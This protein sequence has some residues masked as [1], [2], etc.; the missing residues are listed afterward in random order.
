MS[1]SGRGGRRA[2]AGRPCHS[3]HYGEATRVIRVP[4]SLLPSIRA[5]LAA[6]KRRRQG[7]EEA[8]DIAELLAPTAAVRSVA[9][10]LYSARVAAGFPAPA[11]DDVEGELDLNDYLVR[12]P[13]TTFYVRVAGDSMTGAGIYPDDILIVDRAQEPRHG[14]IVIAVVNGEITVKRLANNQG[15]VRLLAENPAYPPIPIGPD[16]AFEIWGVVTGVARRF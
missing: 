15:N 8:A 2:G 12:R 1:I 13:T 6:K 9:L 5:A 10:T 11:D 7:M 16:T 4:E 3:G 14:C